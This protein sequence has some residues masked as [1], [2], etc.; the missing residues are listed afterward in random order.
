MLSLRRRALLGGAV[1]AAISTGVG[2]I[3]LWS[4]IDRQ[5]E[6]RFDQTLLDR[7]T[8]LVVGLSVATQEP[9]RLQML[10][11]DPSY[12]TP[13]S[14]RYWQVTGSDGQVYTSASLFGET[15]PEPNEAPPSLEVW[16]T[17][18]S[19]GEAIR[20][21][22]QK[23][24]YE[25]GSVW[26]VSVAE[27]QAELISERFETRR[28]LALAFALVGVIGIAGALLLV[29]LILRPLQKLL[30]DVAHR[31]ESDNEFW[32]GDYPEEVAPL[33]GDIN[34]LL[35]RNRDIVN[36]SRR[37]TA[38]L[39]HSL[40]TPTSILRNELETLS[41]NGTNVGEAKNALDRVDAQLKR[42]LARM[43][44]SNTAESTYARTDLSNSIARLS[45]LF[46]TMAEREGK[47][48][49]TFCDENLSVRID[50][51]D[52]EEVIGNLLDNALK[53][54][55]SK[56]RLTVISA[57]GKIEVTVEDDGPGIPEDSKR[58]ALR[59][60]GRLDSSKPGTGLGLAIAVDLL[61]A[62]GA[63]LSLESSASHGG[64]T[65]RVSIPEQLA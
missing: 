48:L 1:S 5:V 37:Q 49:E 60:G 65:A 30:E 21:V 7:H 29:S 9:E 27:S 44:A 40:K 4:Y 16:N 8:Q 43:R 63:N 47:S 50:T 15:F 24:T 14:G 23:I 61:S 62:Y 52:I 51:Q 18:D 2:A 64:L 39:A 20:G 11:F 41:Y 42:S 32:S 6:Y 36:R 58:D 28:S 55:K 46:S 34:T 13:L 59:S 25:D 35:N 53:W 57:G 26:G 19:E 33:V 54:S 31:W 22:Y 10:L 12:R 38:D 56:V 45:R 3:A 17:F